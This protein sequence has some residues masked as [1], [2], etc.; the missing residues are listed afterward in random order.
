MSTVPPLAQSLC[1]RLTALAALPAEEAMSLPAA[2]YT[3]A[4]LLELEQEWIFRREWVCIAHAGELPNPGDYLCTELVGEPLLVVRGQDHEIRVL[5]NVCRHRGNVV[6]QGRGNRRAFTC[7]Y[8]GWTYDHQG[9]LQGAPH[10][11][12][13]VGSSRCALPRFAVS[14]WQGFIF[15]NLDGEAPPLAPRLTGLEGIIGNYHQD[16]RYLNFITEDC[17]ACNW[18]SL[19]ENFMEGYHLSITHRQTLH[20]ITPTARCRKMVA[21]E[22]YTGYYAGYDPNYPPRGP[23][24]PDL[25]E[26]ERGRSPMFGIYP[27]LLVGMATN[28][29]LFMLIRPESP[30]RVAIR[31]GVTGL[32]SDSDTPAVRDYVALCQ[33]FNAE[34]REKLE[35]LQRAMHSRYFLGGPL[36]PED[37]EGTIRDFIGY[38]ARRLG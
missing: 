37:L 10:M 21:D 17:W 30:G 3:S 32:S 11:Q 12:K 5:S 1:Q 35:A 19:F 23:F 31:W 38:L 28:F 24:H 18:K 22:A 34:D 8:H 4:E 16:E 6:A 25:S 33:S 27:N 7:G 15:V 36:G 13:V 14:L 20:P 26:A 9:A 29:T 2:C